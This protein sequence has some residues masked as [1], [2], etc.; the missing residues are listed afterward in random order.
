MM[1]LFHLRNVRVVSRSRKRNKGSLAG[2]LL[3]NNISIVG[4]IHVVVVL[5]TVEKVHTSL[6]AEY[7]AEERRFQYGILRV[8]VAYV[9]F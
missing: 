9:V 2:L 4:S 8:V 5:L 3:Y 1:L 7:V 6:N